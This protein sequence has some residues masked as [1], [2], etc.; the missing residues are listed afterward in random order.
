MVTDLGLAKTY[1][2]DTK[3][4]KWDTIITV[5]LQPDNSD[6]TERKIH[7]II[8]NSKEERN[9][10]R[11]FLITQSFEI[12][13]EKEMELFI[14]RTQSLLVGL[15]DRLYVYS[16][17]QTENVFLK[18]A[19]TVFTGHIYFLLE[20]IET[21]FRKYF[22]ADEKLPAYYFEK[23]KSEILEQ[24]EPVRQILAARAELD[25]TF[26]QTLHDNIE[27]FCSTQHET[28]T[29]RDLIYHKELI[30]VL[31]RLGEVGKQDCM[32]SALKESLIYMDFNSPAFINYFL[33]QFKTLTTVEQLAQHQ[34]EISLMHIKPG[35]RLYPDRPSVK[36]TLI[37]AL[38]K[39]ISF[40]QTVGV[41]ENDREPENSVREFVTVPFKGAE[42]YLLVKSFVDAGGAIGQLYKNL[43]E[44]IAPVIAN[45]T[46]RGFSAESLGKHSDKVDPNVKDNVK[47]FLQKMIRNIES[48][49]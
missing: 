17:C 9:Q 24:Y 10:I 42:I 35:F 45:K 25:K 2:M 8:A 19:Y 34:K 16:S 12:K 21:D 43:L 18:Q 5:D 20:C 7:E 14:Q 1:L 36:N 33:T 13:N 3:L 38:Q 29:Y 49:D 27:R 11:K 37:E 40:L 6:F 39:E 47:R 41:S 22:N 44:R 32:Y 46:Q 48:Y 15:L 26:V 23:S 31:L 30:K 4:D 28:T